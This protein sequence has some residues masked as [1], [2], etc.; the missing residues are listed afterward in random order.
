[1]HEKLNQ[2]SL[3]MNHENKFQNEVDMNWSKKLNMQ[4][5]AQMNI[6]NEEDNKNL[7]Q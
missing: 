1:M 5:W 6:R 2:T 4:N 7:T 3:I